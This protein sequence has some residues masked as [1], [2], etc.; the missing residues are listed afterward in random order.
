MV[1][2]G[3]TT[4]EFVEGNFVINDQI[5]PKE[6]LK[7]EVKNFN[8]N[9]VSSIVTGENSVTKVTI[10]KNK[11]IIK[12]NSIIV[13]GTKIKSNSVQNA[14]S[15]NP[16]ESSENSSKTKKQLIKKINKEKYFSK[17]IL[18]LADVCTLKK[19][20]NSTIDAVK[21]YPYAFSEFGTESEIMDF[22][23]T[24]Y[25]E[26]SNKFERNAFLGLPMGCAS[27]IGGVTMLSLGS[28]GGAFMLAG[29]GLFLG[30]SIPRV[31]QEK[32]ILKANKEN[33]LNILK[34]WLPD[35]PQKENIGDKTHDPFLDFSNSGNSIGKINA[36]VSSK[37]LNDLRSNNFCINK[38][39]QDSI[40]R[41]K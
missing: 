36:E 19:L 27:A 11:I 2:I 24:V 37:K 40:E 22:Y 5:I 34:M 6:L 12:N 16:I 28:I 39:N 21:L 8:F 1:K 33:A 35:F 20:D 41:E 23:D 31:I 7:G 18:K 3:N 29:A 10:G 30:T 14:N 15:S 25:T 32:R 13:N 26:S 4:F 38:P 9:S 17:S